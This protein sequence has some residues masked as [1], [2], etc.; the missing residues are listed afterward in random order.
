MAGEK[1]LFL[2]MAIPSIAAGW[3]TV[4]A[5]NIMHSVFGLLFRTPNS[6]SRRNSYCS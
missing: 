5:A 1:V 3:V 4:R 2:C 6:H